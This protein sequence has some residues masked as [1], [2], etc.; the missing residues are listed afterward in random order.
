MDEADI[1]VK[2]IQAIPNA[3]GALCLNQAGQD[4]LASRPT[5][6]PGYFSI[7]TSERHLRVLQDKENAVIIGSAVDELVRHH[8]V[9]RPAVFDTVCITLSRIEDIGKAYVRPRVR[10]LRTSLCPLHQP[11]SPRPM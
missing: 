9:L 8:P 6:I 11:C 2:V 4:Q 5:I 1:Y 3:I 10:A 7:F